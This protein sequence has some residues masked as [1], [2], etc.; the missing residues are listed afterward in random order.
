MRPDFKRVKDQIKPD[1][2]V[3]EE[4]IRMAN[5]TR[6][7]R[8]I[9][10]KYVPTFAACA[11][12]LAVCLGFAPIFIGMNGN[13]PAVTTPN[14]STGNISQYPIEGNQSFQ[15]GVTVSE[16]LCNIMANAKSNEKLSVRLKAVNLSEAYEQDYIDQ[17]YDGKRYDEWWSDY[18][19]YTNRM[20]EIEEF[21]KEGTNAELENEYNECVEKAEELMAYMSQIRKKQKASSIEKETAWLKSL[22]IDAEYK[23]GYFIFSAT[24]D[25]I[26]NIKGGRCDYLIDSPE[27]TQE[28]PEEIQ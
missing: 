3:V 8:S 5:E 16:Y 20:L 12:V 22:G 14:D 9:I 13:S 6:K 21:L 4:T 1:E 18:E 23:G 15:D 25:E 27:N 24:P 2:A 11:C 26:M 28:S 7:K 19:E 17:L 10:L